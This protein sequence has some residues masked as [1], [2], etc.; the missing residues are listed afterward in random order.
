MQ[1]TV[2]NIKNRAV[3]I[4][5]RLLKGKRKSKDFEI[6]IQKVTYYLTLFVIL[7][8]NGTLERVVVK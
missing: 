6:T 4:E 2:L 7:T 8:L 5:K 3:E 1:V